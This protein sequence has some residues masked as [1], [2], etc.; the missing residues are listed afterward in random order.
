MA[1]RAGAPPGTTFLTG[2]QAAQILEKLKVIKNIE[3]QTIKI[4]TIQTNPQTGTKHIV[5]IPIVQTS[6]AGLGAGPANLS[7]SPMKAAIRTYS[8]SSEGPGAALGRTIKIGSPRAAGTSYTSGQLSLVKG[9]SNNSLQ[10]VA[11]TS[12]SGQ[13]LQVVTNLGTPAVVAAAPSSTTSQ[14]VHAVQAVRGYLAAGSGGQAAS[15]TLT[16]QKRPVTSVP[17]QTIKFEAVKRQHEPDALEASDAKRRKTDKGKRSCQC[18]GSES[19]SAS[20]RNIL[21]DSD[22]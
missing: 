13:A 6:T 12:A 2:T 16:P 7:V 4:Q 18:C 9:P 10:L 1:N 21:Q 17:N 15:I 22:P 5:A 11:A 8:T 19:G 20:L 3:G 14:S